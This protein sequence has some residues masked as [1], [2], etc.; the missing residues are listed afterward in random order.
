MRLVDA[1]LPMFSKGC[2]PTSKCMFLDNVKN[3]EEV[4]V[5]EEDDA[6]NPSQM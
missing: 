3:D 2:K 5:S 6:I 4:E 1:P